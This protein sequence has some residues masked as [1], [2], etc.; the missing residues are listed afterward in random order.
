MLIDDYDS[1]FKEELGAIGAA[2]DK[3]AST[4]IFYNDSSTSVKTMSNMKGLYLSS[5]LVNYAVRGLF[6]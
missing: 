5:K 4:I 6:R 1:L 3:Y 2:S